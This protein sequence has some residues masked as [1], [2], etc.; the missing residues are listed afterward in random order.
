MPA[1]SIVLGGAA[2]LAAVVTLSACG[3]PTANG[4]VVGVPPALH[5]TSS[6]A[7]QP[8]I[9]AGVQQALSDGLSQAAN[10]SA[11]AAH[12][13]VRAVHALPGLHSRFGLGG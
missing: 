9:L 10:A 5:H 7:Y 13:H 11:T 1:P 4:T 6:S 8:E 12:P 3:G 2:A